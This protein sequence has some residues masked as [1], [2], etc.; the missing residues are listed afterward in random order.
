MCMFSFIRIQLKSENEVKYSVVIDVIVEVN[1]AKEN[2]KKSNF[3]SDFIYQFQPA[4]YVL[5]KL[6]GMEHKL[7]KLAMNWKKKNE[8]LFENW[9][10]SII[11]FNVNIQKF[12]WKEG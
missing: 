4:A 1:P 3:I 12:I 9:I 2:Y 6:T 7:I 8:K 11:K 5:G 10:F